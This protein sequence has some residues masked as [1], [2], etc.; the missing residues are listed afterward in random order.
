MSVIVDTGVLYA[1]HD[2]DAAR[3]E[4]ASDALEGVY[5]GVLGQPYVSEYIYDEAVT[6]TDARASRSDDAVALGKRLRGAGSFPP[7]F[8]LLSVSKAEFDDAIDVFERYP[9]Q[10]LSFT[11]ASIV[12]QVER[13]GIDGVLSFDGDFDGLVKRFDPAAVVER[14]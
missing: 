8:E 1:D 10:G 7:A 3:H 13:R 4:T 9:D 5:D 14:Y 2:R 12:A 11:D 6:L